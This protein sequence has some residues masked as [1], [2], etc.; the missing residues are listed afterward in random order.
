MKLRKK[1][2][3]KKTLHVSGRGK[4]I[5]G[6]LLLAL[7]A[8][9]LFGPLKSLQAANPPY[10]DVKQG[11]M[12][13]VITAAGD[14]EAQNE[15]TLGFLSSGQV[16][17]LGFREGDQVQQGQIIA[18]LDS[19]T[20]SNNLAAAQAQYDS[21][22]A[23][24]NK[25]LDDIHLF[26]YG[27]GGFANVGSA[28]E[29]ATQKAQRV[30][31]QE[32]VNV[33][34]DNLQ[35]AQKQLSMLSIAAPF[36]GTILSI[37]N[38]E[39]GTNV[40]PASGS[41]VTVIGGGQLKFVAGVPQQDI[42]QVFVGEPVGIKLDARKDL[43]ISGT[44]T[45]IAADKTTLPGGQVVIKVD[46]A[47]DDLQL[48]AQAGQSGT[49]VFKTEQAN[50]I[51]VPSWTVLENKYVWVYSHG[52]YQLKEVVVGQ[53]NGGKMQIISG[54]SPADRVVTDPQIIAGNKY[55]LL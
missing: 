6:G 12:G 28:N 31:A 23:A 47:G 16:A 21:A 48:V 37:Q 1:A 4:I 33:A 27:N 17:Y 8:G 32:A 19:T 34:Y 38:I 42:S 3:G 5:L 51:T 15:E 22:Q 40:S 11:S 2:S 44:V 45:R 36:G 13:D 46:I 29:T 41:L 10:T 7:V 53:T 30:Q 24:L 43:T 39:V 25:V 9:L 52:N 55:K 35:N 18:S 20:A 26:Q 49:A 50:A 54:L 14:V